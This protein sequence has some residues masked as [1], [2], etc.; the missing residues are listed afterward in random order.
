VT[1]V[2]VVGSADRVARVRG[3]LLEAPGIELAPLPDPSLGDVVVIADATE[4]AIAA[5]PGIGRRAPVVLVIDGGETADG[6]RA[7]LEAGAR[8]CLGADADAFALRRT[9]AAAG[10]L[11]PA[12]AAAEPLPDSTLLAVVGAAGGTGTTTV[13]IAA[14]RAGDGLLID[15]DLAGSDLAT[16]LGLAATTAGIAGGGDPRRLLDG[17]VETAGS[18]RV[19]QVAPCVDLAWTVSAGACSALLREARRRERLVVVD[20][21][22]GSGPALEAILEA[23]AVAVVS[24]AN[25]PERRRAAV[26]RFARLTAPDAR[27]VVIESGVTRAGAV[28]SQ[29][30]AAVGAREADIVLE[31]LRDPDG[32]GR[33][34]LTAALAP[35][36]AELAAPGRAA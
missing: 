22:R 16:R 34:R 9:I 5:V 6:L 33:R 23:D 20:A 35:L 4:R 26:E 1:R 3:I 13:A 11:A 28:R 19:A 10:S 18:L 25:A 12:G 24:P 36:L 14:A 30:A 27:I 7:A 2:A 21:G 17:L 29:I 15:L 8:G 31:R 32:R